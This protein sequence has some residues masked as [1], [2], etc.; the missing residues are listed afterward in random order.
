[1]L[2]AAI[3]TVGDILTNLLI[4]IPGSCIRSVI[5][6]KKNFKG[7]MQ[8]NWENNFIPVFTTLGVLVLIVNMYRS[9]QP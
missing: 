6:R 8:E 3:E 4:K 1:M 5:I 9:S 2:E 7:Y